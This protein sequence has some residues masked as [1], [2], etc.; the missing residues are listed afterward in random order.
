[1]QSDAADA[2]IP[3]NLSSVCCGVADC[4]LSPHSEL[5]LAVNPFVLAYLV[6]VLTTKGPEAAGQ[7]LQRLLSLDESPPSVAARNMAAKAA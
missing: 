6:C 7:E 1:M 5:Q 4:S 3:L 2:A